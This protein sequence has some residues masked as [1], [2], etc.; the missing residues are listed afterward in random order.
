MMSNNR[1]LAGTSVMI[2]MFVLLTCSTATAKYVKLFG[3]ECNVLGYASQKVQYGFHDDF[4]SYEGFNEALNTLFLEGDIGLTDSL[5]LYGSGKLTSDLIYQVIQDEDQW[6]RKQFDQSRDKLNIDDEYWQI[7]NELHATWVVDRL[8][9]RAGKQIVSWGQVLGA[10]ALSQ[11]NPFD[12]RRFQGVDLEVAQIPIWLLRTD[13]SMPVK[14]GF[15][16]D[17]TLQFV[18]NPNA[19]FIPSQSFATGNDV[20]GI[21]ALHLPVELFPGMVARTGS[22]AMNIQEREEWSEGHEFGFRVQGMTEGGDMMTL[23]A[24]YGYANDPVTILDG[25]ATMASPPSFVDGKTVIHPVM[26]G[27][28]PLQRFVGFTYFTEIL[29]LRF[30]FAGG[31][32]PAVTFELRYDFENTY[33]FANPADPF[34]LMYMEDTSDAVS[35]ILNV[36]YKVKIALLNPK[37]YFQFVGQLNYDQIMDSFVR[38]Q[39]LNFRGYPANYTTSLQVMT[40]YLHGKLMPLFTWQRDLYAQTDMFGGSLDYSPNSRWT[41]SVALQT[42]RNMD[43]P[44][45]YKDYV[46]FKIKYKWG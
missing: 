36:D 21:W 3:K 25:L 17:L 14:P 41:Y 32:A 8:M 20:A 4:N 2:G 44:F 24:F 13:Y 5:R 7:L 30:S 19:D 38:S 37:A 10:S 6:T 1:I 9:I 31:V 15:L 28:Y 46:Y 33:A 42:F 27:Y 23:N 11:F 22:A 18:F 43:G 39:Q 29:P 34:G 16:T 26:D 40:T 35:A 45:E 12:L